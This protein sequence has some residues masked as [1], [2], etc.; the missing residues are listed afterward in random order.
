MSEV[1]LAE[2]ARLEDEIGEALPLELPQP[3]GTTATLALCSARS[4]FVAWVGDSRALVAEERRAACT[5]SPASQLPHANSR[6]RTRP[7]QLRPSPHP[8]TLRRDGA[9]GESL[10][11][12][13][14]LTSD[15][16]ARNDAERRRL[17]EAGGS[18]GPQGSA[19]ENHICVPEAE[20]MLLVSRSLG[21]C[22][23]HKGDAVS[24]TPDSCHVEL[25]PTVRALCRGVRKVRK[26]LE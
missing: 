8:Q 2:K 20:G 9:D 10:L 11:C 13:V 5:R 16:T 7:R 26:S 17:L 12:A 19:F 21:D 6:T 22:P 1:L 25:K 3:G 4:L 24:A 14:P 18:T 23:F 15:H